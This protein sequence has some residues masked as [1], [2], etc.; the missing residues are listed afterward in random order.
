MGN[1]KS[2]GNND[3]FAKFLQNKNPKTMPKQSNN[4]KDNKVFHNELINESKNSVVSKG[5]F[6]SPFSQDKYKDINKKPNSDLLFIIE[7]NN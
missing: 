7:N 5:A 3:R 2:D 1:N 6:I 4:Q